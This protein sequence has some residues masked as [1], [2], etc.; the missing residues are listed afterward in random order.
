M[1]P[2]LMRAFSTCCREEGQT[3]VEY[4]LILALV[5]VTAIGVLGIVGGFPSFFLSNVTADL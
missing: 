3:I 5:S 4:A 2:L 1:I